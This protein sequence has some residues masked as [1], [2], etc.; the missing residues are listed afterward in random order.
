M[1]VAPVIAA[2]RHVVRQSHRDADAR[3]DRVL[4][5]DA[6][7]MRDAQASIERQPV[8]RSVLIVDKGDGR[9]AS[10]RLGLAET[11]TCVGGLQAEQRLIALVEP[12]AADACGVRT[13]CE[14]QDRLSTDVLR[15]AMVGGDDRIVGAAVERG[16]IV[17][18][19]RRDRQERARADR[20]QPRHIDEPVTLALLVADAGV[21]VVWRLGN[22]EAIAAHGRHDAQLIRRVRLVN[23][24]TEAADTAGVV[25]N[26]ISHG[27]LQSE[28]RPVGVDTDVERRSIRVIAETD[29]IVRLAEAA[30]IRDQLRF[31]IALESRSRDDVEDAVQPIP[32]LGG[33]TATMDSIVSMSFGSNC[34]PTVV[35]MFVLGTGTPSTSH[36][37]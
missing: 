26:R 35:A 5:D 11:L 25:V 9:A 4:A 31:A 15:G 14:G 12:I 34:G 23:P 32:E 2:Q 21:L 37:T 36:E 29:L 13:A 27:R 18:V 33:V 24:R 16:T 30:V 19:E 8:C 28:I 22:L 20:V 1:I 10:R 6:S 7:E 17:V 3:A